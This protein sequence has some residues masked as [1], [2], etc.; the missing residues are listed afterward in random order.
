M[1][2]A[3]DVSAEEMEIGERLE[4]RFEERCGKDGKLYIGIG[5][6][7]RSNYGRRHSDVA[8]GCKTY[9]ENTPSHDRRL[10][11]ACVKDWVEGRVVVHFHLLVDFHVLT[12][13]GNVVDEFF[14]GC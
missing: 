1:F 10:F 2:L 5:Q 12:T 4:E 9:D 13:S 11:F 7:S 3:S 6:T 14:D 8:H